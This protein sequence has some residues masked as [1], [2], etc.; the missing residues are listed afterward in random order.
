MKNLVSIE[1]IASVNPKVPSGLSKLNYPEVTFLPMS[2]VSEEGKIESPEERSLE[3]VQKGYTYFEQGDVLLA[4]ITPCMENGKAAYVN[5]IPHKI[6]FGSTEF[7]VIRPS[8][9]V[10]GRYLFYMVWNPIFRH[11]AESNMTGTAGQRR[12]PTDFVKRYKIPL[13]PIEEQRRIATILDKADA[14][15]QKRS[16]S[17]ALT[18]ALLRSAFLNMF[19]DPVTNKGVPHRNRPHRIRANVLQRPRTRKKRT[20]S[21]RLRPRHKPQ[22]LH[23]GSRG[24]RSHRRKTILLSLY[25]KRQPQ[26]QPNLVLSNLGHRG[27]GRG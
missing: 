9:S 27:K 7:H 8:S 20:L 13:P 17:I 21:V 22:A 1:K 14:I 18:E 10:E 5:N 24:L 4:K 6:G 16:Q 23:S 25:R 15:R 12:V 19:G 11:H 2:G 3:S 26:R